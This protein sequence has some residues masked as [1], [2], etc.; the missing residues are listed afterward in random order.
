MTTEEIQK[1]PARLLALA[2]LASVCL[3]ALAATPALGAG[4]PALKLSVTAQP[5]EL[6]PGSG[7]EG[8]FAPLYSLLVTNVGSASTTGP[9][10]FTD[11]LPDQILATV[12]LNR[13]IKSGT[14]PPCEIDGQAVTCEVTGALAPGEWAQVL[15]GVEVPADASGIAVNQAS[16]IGGGAG[17]VRQTTNTPI[18]E[19]LPAFDFLPGPT[20]LS[21]NAADAEGR[22]ASAAGSHPY[23]LTV[24]LGFPSAK[25]SGAAGGTGNLYNPAHPKDLKVTLPRGMVVNPNGAGARCTEAQLETGEREAQG[26]CPIAS[27]VGVVYALSEVNSVYPELSPLFEMVPPPG[28]AAEFG[29][30]IAGFGI[31]VHL[32]GGV[33]S[34]GEYELLTDLTNLPTREKNPILTIQTQLWGNPSDESHDAMR[35]GCNSGVKIC[36]T[37]RRD[38]PF[39]TMPGSCRTE[40]SASA[41]VASW[42]DPV[43][44]IAR[45]A[46]LEDPATGLPTSTDGCNA[47]EFEPQVAAK[48]TTNLSDAPTGLDFNLHLRQTTKMEELA[49]ASFKDVRVTFPPGMVVNPSGANGLG[50]CTPAQF[51]L[52]SSVGQLPVRT[53]ANPAN[54]PDDAK[55]GSVEVST[56]LL[57]HP[58]PGALYTA[59]PYQN[60]F[61]SLLAIYL[62]VHDPQTGVV[63]KLAGKVEADPVTGQLTTI[64]NDNPELPIEDVKLRVFGGPRAALKTPLACGQHAIASDVTPWSAPEGATEHPIDSFQT[65][66]AA[67]GSGVCP[68]SEAQAPHH[69][70]FTAGTVAPQ[71]GAYSPFVLKLSREDGTQRLAGIEATLPKGLVARLAGIPYCSEAQIAAAKAREAPSQGALE[72]ASPSCPAASEVGTVNV[73]A[74]AGPL[75]F[76]AQGHV[77][78]AGPYKGA[79]L[80][81]V[82]V[83]PAVAGPFDLGAVVV[84]TALHLDPET[85]EVRAVSD[86][87]PT[88]LEGVPLDVRSVAV[89]VDRSNFTLNPT[90]CDPKSV[91]GSA[92]SATGQSAPLSERFQVGGCKGLKFAP[93][94][95]LSLKGGTKRTKHPALR[96]VLTYPKKGAYANAARAQVTL[97]HSE[98]LDQAHIGTICTR[99]QFAAQQCPRAS[100]YGFARAFTPLLEKPVEGPVY[101]RS[102]SHE[103]PDLVLALRGQIDAAAVARIDTGKGGGIRSTFEAIPDVPLSKVVL[104]MQGGKKGLF[105]NSENICKKPQRAIVD[106]SAQNGKIHNTKPLIRNSCK[107]KQRKRHKG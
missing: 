79:P 44:K 54:C 39:L 28:V 92:V 51:G 74:G 43:T 34:A 91:L 104:E 83:T 14:S 85:A 47:I 105:V 102:S 72:K 31:F 48:P 99:V 36:P 103:L 45:S 23:G 5:T 38:A 58:L 63:S 86:S 101:L 11:V 25:F 55:I 77:Y 27:Q 46:A 61:G 18:G 2:L 71:A 21:L 53:D 96:A 16:V 98:F 1:I 64:F 59:Q 65:S 80:S 106:F 41:I 70:S 37:E 78:L 97:P 4:A 82:I 73:G 22:P 20:G 29:T 40:L 66:I 84:R 87:L 95:A 32:M 94:L 9:I 107:I 75:P 24:E 76:Y 7:N 10:T 100:V 26:G 8:P 3:A 17:E 33:N 35:G 50:A 89:R 57:D 88:I 81:F 12:A 30:N 6:T 60:P 13:D 68:A 19:G 93:K 15:I 69:P 67:S 49:T 56:P 62:A 52:A 90:N 42:E